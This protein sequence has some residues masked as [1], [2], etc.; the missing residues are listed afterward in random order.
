M[1]QFRR[2]RKRDTSDFITVFLVTCQKHPF[3]FLEVKPASHVE[4]AASRAAANDHTRD[5]F[6]DLAEA[7][8]HTLHGFS[9]LGFRQ[10]LYLL[11]TATGE[12]SL[13]QIPR[14]PHFLKD[15]APATDWSLDIL[16]NEGKE[17]FQTV[18]IQ[19]KSDL[20]LIL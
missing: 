9:A 18:V 12:L 8:F 4:G 5:M 1:P 7:R 6:L 20:Q 16:C 11:N 3:L 17:H 14:D 2:P 19:I 15:T 10:Y 13:H